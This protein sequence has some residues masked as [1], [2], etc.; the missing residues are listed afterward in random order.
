MVFRSPEGKKVLADLAAFCR[1]AESTYAPDARL[2]AVL[3]GRREVWLRIQNHLQ[4]SPD[5]LYGLLTN[6]GAA[7]ARTIR[8]ED[9]DAD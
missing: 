6:G 3:E 4:L 5:D 7:P 9:T 8:E 2:H 1:A